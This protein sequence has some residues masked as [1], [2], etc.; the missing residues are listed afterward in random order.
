[1]YGGK[2]VVIIAT[3]SD[4][5]IKDEVLRRQKDGS[6][7]VI[8]SPT[9]ISLYNKYMGGVDLNDQLRGYY[10]LRLKVPEIL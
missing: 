3:N 1:M 10:H 4:P 5:T 9:S 2:P 8:P 7:H 6:R